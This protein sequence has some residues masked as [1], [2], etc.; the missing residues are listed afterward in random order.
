VLGARR[1]CCKESEAVLSYT[2]I[3]FGCPLES[4]KAPFL[5]C[6]S[7]QRLREDGWMD[8]PDFNVE[9][10]RGHP[11]YTLISAFSFQLPFPELFKYFLM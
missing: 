10:S 2:Y 1:A 3:Y 4:E 5:I 7:K 9:D 8:T 11:K 6:S